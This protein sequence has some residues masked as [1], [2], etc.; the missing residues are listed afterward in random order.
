MSTPS[1]PWATYS[2][3]MKRP[4]AS[5]SPA[6]AAFTHACSAAANAPFSGFSTATA[7]ALR[8][9]SIAVLRM[10]NPPPSV[11]RQGAGVTAWLGAGLRLRAEGDESEQR[12]PLDDSHPGQPLA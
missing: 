4:N 6:I 5:V 12:D 8:A 2:S 10:W 1:G 3:A 7:A 11:R 9:N